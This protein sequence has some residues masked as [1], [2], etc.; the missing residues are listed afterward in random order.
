MN[1]IYSSL[2]LFLFIFSCQTAKKVE[3][4]ED[5]KAQQLAQRL[6]QQKQ[7]SLQ[8]TFC[9][10]LV[11][12]SISNE[13]LLKNIDNYLAQEVDIN[14]PCDFEEVGGSNSAETALVNLGVS[15]SNKLFRTKFRK[16]QTKI[17]MV[18]KSYPVLLLFSEDTMMVRQLVGRGANVNKKTKDNFS[19]V[20]YYINQD[21]FQKTQ[22]VFDLGAKTDRL[23]IFSSNEKILDFLVEKGADTQKFDK[24]TLFKGD[25]YKKL[26][27]KYEIDLSKTN[28]EE[29]G[30]IVEVSNFRK[31]NFERTKWLLENSVSSSCM[32][33]DFLEKV[34]SENVD[35][36]VYSSNRKKKPNQHTRKEWIDL[37]NKYDVNWNQCTN[38]GKTPLLL[39]VEKRDIELVKTL[40]S[41]NAD[42]NFACLFAGKKIN[43]KESLAKTIKYAADN[44]MRKKER[45]KEDYSKKDEDRHTAYMKKLDEIKILLE[46]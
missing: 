39:A 40:L 10:C 27:E 36:K 29:F 20:E 33:G 37:I 15:I 22:F 8:Q 25:N 17:K 32:K 6:Q 42:P 5:D 19:L 16:R 4:I 1:K 46:Q 26:A 41:K 31:L 18:T 11:E 9:E 44:E 2:F 28:C 13:K 38:F 21:D 35:G 23:R 12:D 7:D 3:D 45:E 24:T 43:A 34:I 30:E 14:I